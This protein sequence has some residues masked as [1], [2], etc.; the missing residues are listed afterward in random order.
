MV[1]NCA[2]NGIDFSSDRERVG[3]KWLYNYDKQRVVNKI[4]VGSIQTFAFKFDDEL[5]FIP[6]LTYFGSLG[7][8]TVAG[9]LVPNSDNIYLFDF[10]MDTDLG[11]GVFRL[12]VYDNQ[13]E[14][15]FSEYCETVP[16]IS[17]EIAF[18]TGKNSTSQYGIM[19]E[20]PFAMVLN[21]SR[22]KSKT[23]FADKIEY[24]NSFGRKITLSTESNVFDRFTFLE[25]SQYQANTLR[26]LSDMQ[27][28]TINGETYQRVSDWEVISDENTELVDMAADFARADYSE[29]GSS[30]GTFSMP[31][32]GQASETP[33]ILD[34]LNRIKRINYG[35]TLTPKV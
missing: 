7:S 11:N 34:F 26:W 2:Y 21:C 5:F 8:K 4:L 14:M 22:W 31:D 25:L 9:T 19:G 16:S 20:N 32:S 29:F 33:I 27:T 1:Q 12:E 28:F 23:Y 35:I 6:Q 24:E 17:D 18:V 30:A 15:S 3:E 10:E 13:H